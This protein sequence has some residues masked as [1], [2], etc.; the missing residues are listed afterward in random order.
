MPPFNSEA[1]VGPFV[2]GTFLGQTIGLYF[3]LSIVNLFTKKKLNPRFEELIEKRMESV[4]RLAL[5]VLGVSVAG[6]AGLAYAQPRLPVPARLVL[7]L[8]I[9][10]S[11]IMGCAG[12]GL[13]VAAPVAPH[14]GPFD[15]RQARP[16][17]RQQQSPDLRLGQWN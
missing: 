12:E 8:R 15:V 11:A 10:S 5:L 6:L 9:D 2:V 16:D 3:I 1:G 7:Q 14:Q 13:V 17:D 4:T